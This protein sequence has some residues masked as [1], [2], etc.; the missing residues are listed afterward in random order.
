MRRRLLTLLCLLHG[1]ACLPAGAAA[2]TKQEELK[3]IQARIE[4]L[5]EELEQSAE[6]RS[7]AADSLRHSERRISEVNRNLRDLRRHQDE[8]QVELA[9]LG[10]EAKLTEA[11]ARDHQARLADLLRQRYRQGGEPVARLLLSGESLADSQRRL[12]YYAYVGRARGAL[13]AA[14]RDT[15]DKLTRLRQDT[16]GRKRELGDVARQQEAQR[17]ALEK[18]RVVRQGM[19]VKLSERIRQQRK[20]IGALQRDEQRLGKLIERLRALSEARK[21][22]P[23]PAAPKPKPGE[24]VKSVADASLAGIDFAKLK[25]K[26]AFPVAGEIVARFGDSRPAGGPAWKGL[27]IR[28]RQGQEVRAVAS[29]DVVFS[30][31]LRG[32]GNLIILDHGGGYLSLYSNN[33]SL[34]KQAGSR[35]RAGDEVASI[36]NTGGQDE[37]G[38]YFELRHQG[39]PFDPITWVARK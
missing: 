5:K 4:R 20:E 11:D 26:L 33:E 39:K 38:L 31:W 14:H 13:I 30:D 2:D 7:E 19:L 1:L 9:R 18:E 23:A 32:F 24:K 37:P 3:S 29:G 6:D 8:L 16:E 17:G 34:Y 36:G 12:A 27:Y 21:A 10:G 22:K 15:L 28:A 25:G 35:V